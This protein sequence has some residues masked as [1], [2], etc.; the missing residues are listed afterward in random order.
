MRNIIISEVKFDL[1]INMECNVIQSASCT[2]YF[3]Y[4]II[5]MGEEYVD[6]E[7]TSCAPKTKPK[8]SGMNIF[9]ANDYG[10][11][12]RYHVEYEEIEGRRYLKEGDCNHKYEIYQTEDGYVCSHCGEFRPSEIKTTTVYTYLDAVGF[13]LDENGFNDN[14]FLD[15]YVAD[16]K[17]PDLDGSGLHHRTS[18]PDFYDTYGGLLPEVE[19]KDWKE[20]VKCR[21]YEDANG[22]QNEE[23]EL[24]E[25]GEEDDDSENTVVAETE[26]SKEATELPMELLNFWGHACARHNGGRSVIWTAVRYSRDKAI[27]KV[28]DVKDLLTEDEKEW[29]REILGDKAIGLNNVIKNLM[30]IRNWRSND[31]WIKSHTA[32]MKSDAWLNAYARLLNKQ[33]EP[34][35]PTTPAPTSN[36]YLIIDFYNSLKN[37]R[38][39]SIIVFEYINGKFGNNATYPVFS[40]LNVEDAN[41][42]ALARIENWK[43][44]YE[45]KGYTVIV[46]NMDEICI[47]EYNKTASRIA[48]RKLWSDVKNYATLVKKTNYACLI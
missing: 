23:E 2:G 48:M 45:E 40:D 7:H 17:N 9:N 22:E 3:D 15:W 38:E 42:K 31:P 1:S 30:P 10:P 35:K 12:Y 47:K 13:E 29:L 32:Y 11:Q 5:C 4:P 18:D 37:C 39:G 26:F 36:K 34:P 43:K 24:I 44:K 33:P 21:Y 25:L 14:S 41:A 46:R 6:L 27:A 28:M 20:N 8:D 19:D 16:T